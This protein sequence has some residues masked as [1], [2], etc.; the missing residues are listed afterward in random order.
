MFPFFG[1]IFKISKWLFCCVGCF[2]LYIKKVL[3]RNQIKVFGLKWPPNIYIIYTCQKKVKNL[4]SR[5][6]FNKG[7][8]IILKKHINMMKI[9][10]VCRYDSKKYKIGW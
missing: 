9:N 10:L 1:S 2:F 5:E 8:Y 7:N 6:G 4:L 3:T